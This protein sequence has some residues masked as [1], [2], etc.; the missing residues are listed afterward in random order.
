M[1]IT[2]ISPY[3][4][5]ERFPGQGETIKYLFRN[6]PSFQTLCTDYRRCAN[7]LKFWNKSPLCEAPQRRQEYETLLAEL[8]SEIL[9]YLEKGTKLNAKNTS[10][11][12]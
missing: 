11:G 7:A 10:T 12:E 9:Q 3:T 6:N 4:V 2:E 8:E 5:M 1:K